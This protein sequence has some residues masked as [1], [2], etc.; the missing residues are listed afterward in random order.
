MNKLD[1]FRYGNTRRKN[2]TIAGIVSLTVIML[3]GILL[4]AV[5]IF[6]YRTELVTLRA[7]SVDADNTF[8]GAGVNLN[9]VPNVN[10]IADPSFEMSSD[11]LTFVVASVDSGAIYLEPED[12]EKQGIS[13]EEL[14]G[15]L[16]RILSIDE[17]GTMSERY[18][19]TC[20]GYEPARLSSIELIDDE[21]GLL[22]GEKMISVI[23]SSN[24]YTALTEDGNIVCNIGAD[25]QEASIDLKNNE[26]IVGIE[27]T[28]AGIYAISSAGN[29]F[30]AADGR[31]FSALAFA[32]GFES[33]KETPVTAADSSIFAAA[34]PDG[35]VLMVSNGYVT[36]AQIPTEGRIERFTSA[37]TGFLASDS[38]GKVYYS[39][40]GFVFE[41]L[42]GVL[43][44]GITITGISGQGSKF[45]ILTSDGVIT[46]IDAEDG[47]SVTTLESCKDNGTAYRDICASDSGKIVL[48]SDKGTCTAIY[49]AKD[50]CTV[51]TGE[52]VVVEDVFGIEGDRIVYSSGGKL[53]RAAILSGLSMEGSIPEDA[54]ISGD[55]CVVENAKAPVAVYTASDDAAWDEA[56]D[57]NWSCSGADT[58]VVTCERPDGKGL[59]AMLAG[60]GKGVH[61]M[62]QKLNGTSSDC[63]TE[64]TFYR[65]S[66]SAMSYDEDVTIK[67]WVYGDTFGTQGFVIN[68]VGEN[69]KEYSYVF[70]VTNSMTG[71][72]TVRFNISVEGSKTVL[73]DDVYLG[74]DEYRTAGIPEYYQTRL[75]DSGLS[76]IRLDNLMFGSSGFCRNAF[77][78]LSKD[79]V[80]AQIVS[81]EYGGAVKVSACN[82]LEDS[83]RLVSACEAT[84]WFVIG[85]AASQSDI[86]NFLEYLCGSV[87]SVYG[88]KR[89][90]NGTA[91][92]WSRQFD[93]MIVEICDSE[94]CFAS[95]TQKASYVNCVMA[96]FAAS[97]YYADVKDKI[98]FLDGMDYSGGTMLSGADSHAMPVEADFADAQAT[99]LE[100]IQSALGLAQY[101]SPH[102]AT[103]ASGGEF[104]SSLSCGKSINAGEFVSLLI[105]DDADFISTAAVDL[106]SSFVPAQY[107]GTGV[108]A[109]PEYADTVLSTI[110]IINCCKDMPEVYMEASEPL[111]AASPESVE[112]L[113]LNCVWSAYSGNGYH[114]IVVANPSDS[115]QNFLLSVSAFLGAG[116]TVERY[117]STGQ[118]LTTRSYAMKSM[119]YT[120]QP[121]EFI[122]VTVKD[123]ES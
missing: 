82:S 83:L 102:V 122:I 65:I 52:N 31:N 98:I 103:A 44:D 89:I 80:S 108:F 6:S 40:N 16:V 27:S 96:M 106:D 86:D 101:N 78:G 85:S 72:D 49:E 92:P 105:S 26:K 120:L 118:L 7:T 81:A 23:D 74:P 111:D 53:Y 69:F 35:T 116:A 67:V 107:G 64:D 37:G 60:S 19:G 100:N 10:L 87:S 17:N 8:G 62:S 3:A 2:L 76:V 34:Y 71:D 123:I 97:E 73:I 50:E 12:I 24:S 42:T 57:S 115:Q 61:I 21:S 55:I 28:D 90:D 95:D 79:S 9:A 91:L 33:H 68:N 18:T 59:C 121:G 58:A 84:P 20:T 22:A 119:R 112:L 77:Y 38:N 14:A 29:V 11:Y 32:E 30:M 41:Q 110:N 47:M 13:G 51:F 63:F 109:D 4:V 113:A 46:V 43:E 1:R 48:V 25:T 15:D 36:C 66:L 88:S 99:S 70:A 114:Y 93:K 56:T 54:I 75:I 45:Y 117:S 5:G 39:G 104:I 94:N